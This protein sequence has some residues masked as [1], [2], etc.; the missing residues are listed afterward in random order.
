MKTIKIFF[1]QAYLSFQALFGWA[2]PFAYLLVKII[3]PVFQ[4]SFFCIMAKMVYQDQEIERYVLGN[5]IVLCSYNCVFGLG[6]ALSQERYFGTLK[7]LIVSPSNN[8]VTF[9][10][11]GIIH[12]FDSIITVTVALIAGV[13]LFQA[14]FSDVN[15][16]EFATILTVGI[17][18]AS[19][20]GLLLA[21]FGLFM[22]NLNMLLNIFGLCFLAFTGANYPL[23][24][25]PLLLRGLSM[26]LPLT[27]S[28]SLG[29]VILAGGTI[30][31][32]WDL[33]L[34]EFVI[35]VVYIFLGYNVFKICEKIA[36]YKGNLDMY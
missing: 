5:A 9:L 4:L 19:S 15:F 12:I 14:D 8:C 10:Q 32:R 26:C 27:R 2:R 18:A 24:K 21:S 36:R 35:G 6:K 3:N 11:R 34:G 23:E 29:D 7:T 30:A 20:L 17:F 22:D 31:N 33:L 25:L 13:I 16:F 1:C 28:I